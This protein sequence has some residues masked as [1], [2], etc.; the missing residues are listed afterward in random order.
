MCVEGTFL[1]S[2]ILYYSFEFLFSFMISVLK[3]K[4]KTKKKRQKKGSVLLS[5][6]YYHLPII[7]KKIH[8]YKNIF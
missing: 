8:L 1:F 7:L 2:F 4:Q 5:I 3:T 6:T